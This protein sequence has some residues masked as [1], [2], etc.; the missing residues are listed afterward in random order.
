MPKAV[1][2]KGQNTAET[3]VDSV[4]WQIAQ[5][6]QPNSL[7]IAAVDLQPGS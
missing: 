1:V 6:N 4:I 7:P 3:E 2:P 5:C